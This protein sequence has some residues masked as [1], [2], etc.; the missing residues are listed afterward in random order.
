MDAH[1]QWLRLLGLISHMIQETERPAAQK[2]FHSIGPQRLSTAQRQLRHEQQRLLAAATRL[3]V[4]IEPDAIVQATNALTLYD[5][6]VQDYLSLAEAY[7]LSASVAHQR[8]ETELMAW[9]NQRA[10]LHIEHSRF[11]S[12]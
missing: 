8:G 6:L 12:S 3:D 11:L 4:A 1:G 5:D 10:R 2:L 9:M 7:Q